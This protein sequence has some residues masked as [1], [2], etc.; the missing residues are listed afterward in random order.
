MHL[1]RL[2]KSFQFLAV[3]FCALTLPLSFFY[4]ALSWCLSS[5]APLAAQPFA[6]W[7]STAYRV[8]VLLIALDM[9]RRYFDQTLTLARSRVI[10]ARG[11]LGLSLKRLSIAYRDVRDIRI[12]QSVFGRFLN[13]GTIMLGTASTFHYEVSF[14]GVYD[15]YTVAR[16]IEIR[17]AKARG[18]LSMDEAIAR[19]DA[20]A[21]EDS[22]STEYGREGTDSGLVGNLAEH[23][24]L[25]E[26][27]GPIRP[28]AVGHRSAGSHP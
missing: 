21:R 2:R 3:Y 11:I 8:A 6:D 5:G 25:H 16:E 20:S 26:K 18:R 24:G 9:V 14:R 12:E 23:Q 22:S 19:E 1:K 10:H 4:A 17:C 7:L 27:Q 15:P 28:A 13:Y